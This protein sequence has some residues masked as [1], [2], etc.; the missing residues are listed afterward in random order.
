M[1][2]AMKLT[3]VSGLFV[4]VF[5]TVQAA[6]LFV[7]SNNTCAGLTPCYTNIQ[8][9]VNN[10]VS[11][12]EIRVFPG[13]YAENIDISQMG[14]AIGPAADGNI[15]FITVDSNNVA[16]PQT[17]QVSPATGIA[18]THTGSFFNGNLIIDGFR[19]L[20]TDD[21]GIDF[22]LIDGDVSVRNIV[23]N[24]NEDDGIDL[25]VAVGNHT[26][27]VMNTVTNNNGGSGLNLDGPD[28]TTV[29]VRNIEANE[30]NNEGI[31]IDHANSTD[32]LS[33]SIDDALT[34]GNGTMANANAGTVVS[35]LGTLAVSNLISRSNQGPGLAIID[36][37]DTSIRD[38]VFDSNGINTAFDGIYTE[39]AGVFLI[40]RSLFT[41]NGEA[42]IW[43]T[44]TG[45]IG[46]DLTDL[47]ITCSQFSNNSAGIYLESG[48]PAAANYSATNN[49][50]TGNTT[51]G[52]HS[53][54]NNNN[55]VATDNWWNDSTGPT[56]ALNIGGMGDAVSDSNDTVIVGAQGIINYT[57]F[58][59]AEVGVTQ[60][61]S[62]TLFANNFDGNPCSAF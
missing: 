18:F 58:R 33:V 21:D 62:D 47:T 52:M 20:S 6:P 26:I 9:A 23:S 24:G 22:D 55:I 13:T 44:N 46:I 15:A 48:L 29:I 28:G 51:A 12:D 41:N 39:A 56:H 11:D 50:I 54:I 38:S 37:T 36:T 27:T 60:F 2:T 59:T 7:D 34:E 40:E 42:G 45:Q 31:D 43:V 10:A 3:L 25:E 5:Q 49:N 4:G 35:T 16:M 30:N 14:S 61:A 19:T 32:A 1:K 53:E 17:V 57:P 8:T